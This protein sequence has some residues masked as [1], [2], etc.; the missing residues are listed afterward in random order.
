MENSTKA[1][2][3]I[4]AVLLA[5]L[6]IGLGIY[7]YNQASNSI[8]DTG[9]DKLNKRQFNA[10]FEVYLDRK[11]GATLAGNLIDAINKN[12]STDNNH[13]VNL[14]GDITDKADLITGKDYIAIAGDLV[15][16]YI[17]DITLNEYHE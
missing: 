13:T 8:G 5:I 15:N 14:Q 10:Q 17:T 9:L 1:L 12:N 4:G 6:L 3:I 11:M 16:G 7:V 2:I